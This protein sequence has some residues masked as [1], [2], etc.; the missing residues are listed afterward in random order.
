M[1]KRFL[2][3]LFTAS[4]LTACQVIAK[5]TPK[6]PRPN[7]QLVFSDEFDGTALNARKWITCLNPDW[8]QNHDL[9]SIY[10]PD[11]V[12]VSDGTAKLTAQRENVN[13]FEYTS[14]AIA[15]S[16]TFS[17]TYGYMEMRAKVPKGR[18]LWPA[19]WALRPTRQWPP[20]IDVMEILGHE[21]DHV[22]LH[23]H[24]VDLSAKD[25]HG[26]E[27]KYWK[28]PNFSAGFHTFAVDWRPDLLV[29]YVDGV[30]RYRN[31]HAPDVP[32]Y[33]I[34]NLA[35]GAANSWPGAPDDTTAF[36][37]TYEID[38]IRVYQIP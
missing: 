25:N 9:L 24:F 6:P 18:G 5:P 38:Y 22:H 27:G 3:S 14:G 33:L 29:W 36:P 28:G 26:N 20:E 13:G 30:E 32:M 21:P 34:A 2:I 37:A 8:C 12:T 35:V 7:L 11:N 17:L 23:T 15:T 16:E 4:I 19:F 10:Q 31:T 1:Q